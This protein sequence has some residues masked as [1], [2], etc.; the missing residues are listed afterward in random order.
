ME[1]SKNGPETLVVH[2]FRRG[3]LLCV[4]PFLYLFIFRFVNS[5]TYVKCIYTSIHLSVCLFIFCKSF[6][7]EEKYYRETIFI[8][9][10][11]E[12]S[13]VTENLHIFPGQIIP[14]SYISLKEN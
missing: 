6:S 9:L 2:D 11:P 5:F 7:A 14:P 13:T 3:G 10:Q 4:Y 8:Y 12:M 1:G